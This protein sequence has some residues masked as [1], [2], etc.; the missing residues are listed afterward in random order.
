MT[1]LLIE[2]ETKGH[3]LSSYLRSIVTELVK[4]KKKI[5]FLTT[6]EIK[7]NNFYSFFNKYTKIIYINK[8]K[9]P[10]KKNYFS[11]LKFQITNYK[12]IKEK[13]Q[14][15]KKKIILIIFM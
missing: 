9:Y 10:L 3:H 6:K 13:F 12:I 1:I 4:N 2:L 11:F 15:I 8:I 5:I 7:K 14:Q